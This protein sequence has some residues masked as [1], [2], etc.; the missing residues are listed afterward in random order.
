MSALTWRF[1]VTPAPSKK[2]NLKLWTSGA[3]R[4]VP[5]PV[6][7]VSQAD[8]FACQL[9]RSVRP[10]RVPITL[11]VVGKYGGAIPCAIRLS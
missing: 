1:T 6:L 9:G 8:Q 3:Y 7:R 2:E 4:L 5:P 10:V 11:P